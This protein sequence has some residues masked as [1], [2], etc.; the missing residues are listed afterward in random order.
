M[1]NLK[2]LSN[3]S[4]FF[5]ILVDKLDTHDQSLLIYIINHC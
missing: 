3:L 1:A 4:K 2:L 5:F